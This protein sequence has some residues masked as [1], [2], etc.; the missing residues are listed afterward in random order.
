MLSFRLFDTYGRDYAALCLTTIH[1]RNTSALRDVDKTPPDPTKLITVPALPADAQ[2][3]QEGKTSKYSYAVKA[4][5]GWRL[6]CLAFEQALDGDAHLLTDIRCFALRISGRLRIQQR[7][8]LLDPVCLEHIQIGRD[9][10]ILEDVSLYLPTSTPFIAHPIVEASCFAIERLRYDQIKALPGGILGLPNIT[11]RPISRGIKPINN[12]HIALWCVGPHIFFMWGLRTGKS[13]LLSQ[14]RRFAP[15]VTCSW[16]NRR[17]DRSV[18]ALQGLLQSLLET[19]RR[20]SAVAMALDDYIYCSPFLSVIS[21]D[22]LVGEA[23]ARGSAF[24]V[25]DIRPSVDTELDRARSYETLHSAVEELP[26]RQ[27]VVILALYFAGHT[28]TQAARFLKISAA[29]VIKLRTKALKRL[30]TLLAPQRDTL[31]I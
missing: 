26:P 27:R 8:K 17:T 2:R 14:Y 20:S 19:Y 4:K 9:D 24:E 22:Q 3:V 13:L 16:Q 6:L 28:V 7:R 23:L 5:L 30:L 11:H 1:Y 21:L 29:A 25:P 10:V 15:G 18:N 12:A 31:F